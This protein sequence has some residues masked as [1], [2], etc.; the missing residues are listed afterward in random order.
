MV[1]SQYA[2][3][4]DFS[5]KSIELQ[6]T[7]LG[8]GFQDVSSHAKIGRDL[9]LYFGGYTFQIEIKTI[10]H[11]TKKQKSNMLLSLTKNE[12][13]RLDKSKK[14]G[15]P[16]LVV[17]DTPQILKLMYQWFN[18]INR[19]DLVDDLIKITKLSKEIYGNI[20]FDKKTNKI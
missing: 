5:Q 4:K 15:I 19:F 11:L 9:D 20:H 16:Y 18:A 6:L 13:D 14:Y 17:T 7:S 1:K 2:K 10:D 3:R 8:F 12:L